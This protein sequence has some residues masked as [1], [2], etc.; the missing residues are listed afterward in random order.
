MQSLKIASAGD[1]HATVDHGP[2]LRESFE[3]AALDADVIMLAGDLTAD[4]E[5]AEVKVLA[6]VCRRLDVPR[7]RR[8]AAPRGL[9]GDDRGDARD[10]PRTSA[11]LALRVADRALALLADPRHARRRAARHPRAPWELPSREPD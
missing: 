10:R 3:R 1:I 6:D 11:R 7:L 4:G 5:P 9:C 2:Q 8:A